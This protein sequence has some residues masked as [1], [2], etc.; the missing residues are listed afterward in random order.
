MNLVDVYL[1]RGSWADYLSSQGPVAGPEGEA[2]GVQV[3]LDPEAYQIALESGL[4]ALGAEINGGPG[5]G[6]RQLELGL[7]RLA[8]GID[9]LNADFNLLFGDLVWRMELHH[10]A[11]DNILQEIRLAEFER[12]A[13]AYRSRAERAYRH[14]WYAEALGDFLEAEK[15]NY[16]D[17]AVHRSLASIYLY[18]LADLPRALAYFRRAARYARPSDARQAAEAHYFAGVIHGLGQR[19]AE[20]EEELAAAVALNPRLYEAHYQRAVL[21]ALGGRAEAAAASLEAAIRGDARYHERARNDPG[22]AAARPAVTLLL[23]RLMRPVAEQ[24]DLIRRETDSLR[25]YVVTAPEQQRQLASVFEHVDAQSSAA[26]TYPAG[27]RFLASVSEAQHEIR[28]LHDDFH[29]HH[30]ID[31]RDYVRSVA[32]S[33]DGRLLAAGFLSAGVKVWEASTGVLIYALSGHL[34]G[35]NSVA[36]SPDTQWLASGSRDRTIKLWDAETGH[37]I[38]SLR[39]HESEV[40]AVTFSPDGLWLASGSADRTLRLWRVATGREI[41]PLTGH[42]HQVTSAVFSP[43]GSLLAS[44]S[45]DRT[46]KLWEAGTGRAVKTLVGHARGVASL[47]FSPDG[48]HLASGG[49]DKCVKVWEVATGREVGTLRGHR[50]DVTSVAFS[51][52]GGLLAA[53]SLGQTIIIWKLQTGA[54][55]KRLRYE[56]ISYHSVAFS[57]KGEWL[58]LASRDLQLWL[59]VILTEEEY[60]AIKASEERA[61][62]PSPAASTPSF[63]YARALTPVEEYEQLLAERRRRG[64]CLACGQQLKFSERYLF[65][66]R[67]RRHRRA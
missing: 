31:P 47:A 51:P 14:G 18:H 24:L 43:D 58:A 25:G 8:G 5:A 7:E 32:F 37:L 67:C 35:V 16:P 45:V 22:F 46:I 57:P 4:G 12:E 39:G 1:G 56:E 41:E 40:R 34:A 44:G 30:A 28:L 36:F 61:R 60:R 59:K 52:D 49:E 62:Q 55:V 20:G 17:F 13:R 11:L 38:N 33:P 27:L 64:R 10:E 26:Q 54:V 48:R 23:D 19:F 29:R 42:A 53:G 21:A 50:N 9:Q 6:R 3:V 66:G 65:G 15:R 2:R 63:N